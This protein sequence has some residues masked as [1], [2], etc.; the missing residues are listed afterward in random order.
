[1]K[2][3]SSSSRGTKMTA[4]LPWELIID[5]LLML[6]VKSLVRFKCVCKS[7]LSLLCDPH[8]AISH[9]QRLSASSTRLLFIAP[10]S[11]E[12]RSIDFNASLHDDSASSTLNL[13][14]LLPSTPGNV[15]IIGS[16]RGLLLLNSC[17]SLWV[18]NPSTGVH[19]KLS[20]TPIESNLM[21]A[22]FFTFLYGFG[23]DP[24]TDDYLVVKASYNPFPLDSATTRVEF[25]SLRNNVWRDCEATHLSYRNY[26]KGS[27]GIREGSLFNGAIHWLA[28]CCNGPM[29]VIVVFDL[30][31]RSFS[32]ILLPVECLDYDTD[33]F[34]LGVL[35]DLL[36]IC[37]AAWDG[38]LEIWVMEEYRV[39]S[40]WTK[41]I[42]VSAEN[43]P[44][45][46]YFSPICYTKDGDI[47]GTDGWTGLAKY[48]GKGQLQEHRSYSKGSY[49]SQVAV[50]TESLLS[51]PM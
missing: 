40:S 41:T 2:G 8:F 1:M 26:S 21:Q 29:D 51:F 7:W 17:Q 11:P 4:I 38:S 50:Y 36:S 13:N 28:F 14:F 39:Q 43:I 16:C 47:F 9:F 49:R 32:E 24:S 37:F 18:W 44:A 42:V 48:N 15:Q 46:M 3:G 33:L 5:I 35:G 10:P 20:S 45:A 25:F 23:Y 27:N 19:R 12:I 22:M 30:T 34:I 6:P 31:E